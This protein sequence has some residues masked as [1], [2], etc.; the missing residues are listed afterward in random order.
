MSIIDTDNDCT[1]PVVVRND[2]IKTNETHWRSDRIF[3]LGVLVGMGWGSKRIASDPLIHSTMD[4]VRHKVCELGG[5]FRDIRGMSVIL[6]HAA[7]DFYD[8]EA[9][10]RCLTREKLIQVMLEEIA[11][12]KTLFDN[13]MD[14]SDRF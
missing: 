7:G 6:R 12:D 10:K 3:R 14:D 4:R 8:A 11:K 5:G 2:T 13:I 1:F 9:S